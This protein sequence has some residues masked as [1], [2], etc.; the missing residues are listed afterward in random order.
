MDQVG[1]PI[2]CR[3]LVV[4]F[5]QRIKPVAKNVRTATH[6]SLTLIDQALMS[7][8]SF[9]VAVLVGRACSQEDFG[10]FV[11]GITLG[12]LV[13]GIP[14]ALLWVP[15]STKAPQQNSPRRIA[16]LQGASTVLLLGIAVV[17]AS[18]PLALAILLS[19]LSAF[20]IAVPAPQWL[21]S[22][23]TG[24]AVLFF[25][26]MIREH[27][28]RLAIAD[29]QGVHLLKI[30]LIGCL[31]QV[32]I[33]GGLFYAGRLT[34]IT[35]FYAVSAGGLVCVVWLG[36]IARRFRYPRRL[37]SVLSLQNWRFGKW[38]LAIAVI[39]TLTDMSMRGM[40]TGFH[41]AAALGAF[42]A[43]AL[44]G[45][46]INPIVLAATVFSRSLAAKIFNQSGTVG[47]SRFVMSAT[48]TIAGLLAIAVAGLSAV[49]PLFLRVIFNAEL[50]DRSLVTAVAFGLCAQ[51]LTIPVEGAQMV[52]EQGRNLFKV[53]VISFALTIIAG[54]PL[55]WAW[56]GAGVGITMGV[57][58][59][60]VLSLHL[61]VFRR[62]IADR[63]PR[64][65]LATGGA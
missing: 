12:W 61:A 18:V 63:L 22:Y 7:L 24:I 41:G 16:G 6:A 48:V 13:L 35:G 27:V 51:A 21:G 45:N 47:L 19:G 36:A 38:L 15:Y 37:V 32:L 25:S 55:I 10:Y 34:L 62:A 4:N 58:A 3:R 26:M 44:I 46:I 57:R 65:L 64:T 14:N 40:L 1:T 49:G 54:L 2:G 5:L 60:A 43:A 30:D 52:M 59:V 56:D 31:T 39:Y 8:T 17:V 20:Q 28:R 11:L 23:L 53:S 42:S 33:A 29:F 9:V 50:A